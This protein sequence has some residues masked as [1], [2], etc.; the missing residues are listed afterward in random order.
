MQKTKG[1]KAKG[2]AKNCKNSKGDISKVKNISMV[3]KRVRFV[4]LGDGKTVMVVSKTSR[5]DFDT[6]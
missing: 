1:N 6:L 5:H 4:N 2:V 3:T